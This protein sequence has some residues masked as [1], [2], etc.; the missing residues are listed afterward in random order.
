MLKIR[1]HGAVITCKSCGSELSE[2]VIDDHCQVFRCVKCRE[3]I[4]FGN[5]A[6]VERIELPGH[7]AGS[8]T[9]IH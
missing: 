2:E 8:E 1:F 6:R 5:A 3:V 4:A 7:H 9:G